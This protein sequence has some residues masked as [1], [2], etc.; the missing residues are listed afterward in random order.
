[1]ADVGLCGSL[2]RKQVSF[3]NGFNDGRILKGLLL[4]VLQNQVLFTNAV[5]MLEVIPIE[6]LYSASTSAS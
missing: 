2:Q 1:M 4:S 5:V 3:E 6:F